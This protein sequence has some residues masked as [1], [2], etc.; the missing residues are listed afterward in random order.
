VHS[1]AYI[2]VPGHVRD[3]VARNVDPQSWDECSTFWPRPAI[4]GN[5][6]DSATLANVSAS[7]CM[8][9]FP[10][11]V[12]PT[13]VPA[14]SLYPLRD[15]YE[16][17]RCVTPPCDSEFKNILNVYTDHQPR[18]V[19]GTTVTAYHMHYSLPV[20]GFRSSFDG[21]ISGRVQSNT[22]VL[23]SVDTGTIDV[24]DAPG[25]SP[26]T[27]I[28]ADKHVAFTSITYTN[29]LAAILKYT[30]LNEQLA[31]IVCCRKSWGP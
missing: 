27:H 20:C 13:A 17:F 1:F 26:R 2:S 3:L 15:F 24:W 21:A 30:E 25:A 31:E 29:T 19:G 6:P 16:H 23:T 9:T 12:Q 5:P 18:D 10:A 7:G 14:G 28:Q 4:S 22:S 11:G 8:V